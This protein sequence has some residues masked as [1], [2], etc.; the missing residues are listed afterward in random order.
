M[1][2][3]QHHQQHRDGTRLQSR[4]ELRRRLL[5][6][7]EE[8]P[9]RRRQ[10]RRP[11]T[12]T[13]TSPSSS[14]A[15]SDDDEN[16]AAYTSRND[17]DRD[18]DD[19]DDAE[20]DLENRVRRIA[21]QVSDG[22]RSFFSTRRLA[23]N[24]DVLTKPHPIQWMFFEEPEDRE[25]P[26]EQQQQQQQQR[27]TI[28]GVEKLLSRLGRND[29]DALQSYL[30]QLLR[31]Q[32]QQEKGTRCCYY[33]T[34][35]EYASWIR[36]YR[37]V[38]ALLLGG[39]P[40]TAAATATAATTITTT[41]TAT[42]SPDDAPAQEEQLSDEDGSDGDGVVDLPS[43]YEDDLRRAANAVMRRFSRVRV[44]LRLQTYVAAE[45]AHLRRRYRV[46]AT[47][48]STTTASRS[49]GCALLVIN[50]DDLN[51]NDS[52]SNGCNEYDP[53]DGCQLCRRRVPKQFLLRFDDAETDI[54]RSGGTSISD[55]DTDSNYYYHNE[56]HAI[57]DFQ[58]DI[59]RVVDGRNSARQSP[60]RSRNRVGDCCGYCCSDDPSEQRDNDPQQQ[61]GHVICELCFWNDFLR[62][63]EYRTGDVVQC[64]VCICRGTKTNSNS[65]GRCVN[66]RIDN[67]NSSCPELRRQRSFEKY[68]ALP[69]DASELKA[70]SKQL[71]PKPVRESEYPCSTWSAAAASMVGRTQE[72][73]RDKFFEYVGKRGSYHHVRACLHEGI[74][75]SLKNEY[76]Q[77][78]LFV[79]AWYG[80]VSIVR[81]LLRY[82]SDPRCVAHGG[83]SIRDAAAAETDVFTT[84]KTEPVAL[85]EPKTAI[86]KL[87][88]DAVASPPSSDDKSVL[89]ASILDESSTSPTTT[90]PDCNCVTLIDEESDHCG[91][92]SYLIDGAISDKYVDALISL[93]SQIPIEV[94]R[95]KEKSAP[96]SKRSYFCDVEGQLQKLIER[97]MLDS[98]LLSS[99]SSSS[100]RCVVYPHVRFLCYDKVGTALPPHVDLNRTHPFDD[101]EE[102]DDK[103]ARQS[104]H[105]FLLYLSDCQQGGETT[106]LRELTPPGR[107]G[108]EAEALATVSPRRGRL[109]LFPHRC[110]HRGEKAVDLPKLLVRGEVLLL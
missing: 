83:I 108:E 85:A 93:W 1:G 80:H 56:N 89:T 37:V 32:Q 17:N 45:L 23:G 107:D 44:P 20:N 92:G 39:I 86:L 90:A 59:L 29:F 74:D 97:A 103:K 57:E 48:S 4:Y 91:A 7:E 88:D 76:G 58:Y 54:C 68:R 42:A 11:Q 65:G 106:L 49:N 41:T 33:V 77:T 3:Q 38:S 50:D 15:A 62:N 28:V 27:M 14:T 87:I 25:L 75:V 60:C 6:H 26:K 24:Y 47:T 78:G 105:T 51:N 79:A 104:S 46:A 63:F 53:P 81:L 18:H 84:S 82:G 43:S 102:E 12:T 21:R 35:M 67:E 101:D 72:V 52:N 71:K 9:L 98:G 55:G 2:R 10:L 100:S 30:L 5:R 99:S 36:R 110:P 40:P 19:H 70:R 95:I 66:A 61:R 73:R 96:C 16:R 94:D 31:L 13:T 109:L 69:K 8:E 22:N 34:L 64:P